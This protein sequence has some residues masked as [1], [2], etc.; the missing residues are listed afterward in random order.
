MQSSSA[1][2]LDSMIQSVATSRLTLSIGDCFCWIHDVTGLEWYSTIFL[3]TAIVRYF[4]MGQAHI[5][6]RKVIILY[7]VMT[8]YHAWQSILLSQKILIH[9][10]IFILT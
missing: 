8:K 3:T 4:I 6:S 2:L 7:A 9:L 1:G 10:L 5:T